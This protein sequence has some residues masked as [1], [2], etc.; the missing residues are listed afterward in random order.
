V[1]DFRKEDFDTQLPALTFLI[2]A[3]DSQG[4]T[5][6]S[7]AAARGDVQIVKKLL[8]CGADPNIGSSCDMVPLHF[9]M[10]PASPR[11]IVPLLAAGANV[12]YMSNWLQTPLHHAAAYKDDVRFLEPLIDSGA[13]VNA[14]DFDGNT[15]LGCAALSDHVKSIELLLESGAN[16]NNR[17]LRGWTAILDAVDSNS[18]RSITVLLKNGADYTLPLNTG[19]TVLHRAAE[20]GDIETI[21]ILTKAGMKNLPIDATNDSGFCARSVLQNRPGVSSDLASAFDR[22]LSSIQM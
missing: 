10:R 20:R 19:C 17:D 22:L 5:A 7:W 3:T 16:I 14:R 11:S 1:L 18:H 8:R 9:A 6:L 13:D 21:Q 4:R 2:N 15:P 12:N